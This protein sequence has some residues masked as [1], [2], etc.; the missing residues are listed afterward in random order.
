[1][2]WALDMWCCFTWILRRRDI[3]AFLGLLSVHCKVHGFCK[4]VEVLLR[5]SIFAYPVV[6]CTEEGFDVCMFS[7]PKWVLFLISDLRTFVN[8]RIAEK[9]GGSLLSTQIVPIWWSRI[10]KVGWAP[11]TLSAKLV[12]RLITLE[13]KFYWSNKNLLSVE[14]LECGKTVSL[15]GRPHSHIQRKFKNIWCF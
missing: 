6:L 12:A 7:L 3:A 5:F 1:M 8:V 10:I 11:V 15:G 13:H 4:P 14:H 2:V 9:P